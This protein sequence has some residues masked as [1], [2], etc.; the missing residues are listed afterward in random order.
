MLT[1]DDRQRLV[2]VLVSLMMMISMVAATASPASAATGDVSITLKKASGYDCAL[3]VRAQATGWRRVNA[4]LRIRI[5]YEGDI[6]W[7]DRVTFKGS[8][9][10]SRVFTCEEGYYEGRASVYHPDGDETDLDDTYVECLGGP[11][12]FGNREEEAA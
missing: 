9:G 4:T 7:E 3:S 1:H 2:A 6:W 5:R 11:L 12:P 10:Y 8:R